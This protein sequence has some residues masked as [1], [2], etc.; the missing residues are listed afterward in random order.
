[1]DLFAIA[2]RN[3]FRNP[4]RTILNLVAIGL[5][6]LIILT[7]KGWIAGFATSAYQTAIDLDT[8]HAQVLN[9]GVRSRGPAAAA[10]S[11]S[12]KRLGGESR[13]RGSARSGGGG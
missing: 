7:M 9:S 6:V 12:E 10:R 3:V 1:M 13:R 5:G 2:I 4:R 8:A 11:G